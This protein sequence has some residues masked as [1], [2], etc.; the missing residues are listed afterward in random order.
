MRNKKST[1]HDVNLALDV[2]AKGLGMGERVLNRTNPK[3][4]KQP[5]P[6]STLTGRTAGEST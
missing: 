4:A 3:R 1:A 2:A 5:P 6:T